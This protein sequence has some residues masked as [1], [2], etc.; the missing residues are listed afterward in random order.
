[1]MCRLILSLR[2]ATD[3]TVVRVW[4]VDHFSP[5]IE[6]QAFNRHGPDGG[7]LLGP[8]CFRLPTITVTSSR[9][10]VESEENVSVIPNFYTSLADR[11]WSIDGPR[12]DE[13]SGEH[14][15]RIP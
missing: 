5:Q 9:R 2:K 1:M 12:D 7:A 3:P 13:H 10:G 6:T 8:M 15:C 11:G 4:N 14:G